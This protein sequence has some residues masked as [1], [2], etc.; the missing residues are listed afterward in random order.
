MKIAIYSISKNEAKHV[1]RFMDSVRDADYV[2]VGDT[3]STDNTCDL[4]VEQGAT[5]L[6]VDVNPWRFDV[7]RNYVLDRLPLDVDVAIALD[8]DEI[9]CFDW[10]NIIEKAWEVNNTT[11]LIYSFVG[12]HRAD[13][14]PDLVFFSKK[15]HSRFGYEWKYPVHETLYPKH[16][17]NEIVVGAPD[18]FIEHFPDHNKPRASYLPLLEL[19][20]KENPDNLQHIMYLAR[21]YFYA[22]RLLEAET[23]FHDFIRREG[24]IVER[25][26]CYRM[27][28]KIAKLKGDM[29][30]HYSM[31]LKACAEKPTER[32]PW[33]DLLE[34]YY[35]KAEWWN[36]IFAAKQGMKIEERPSH[37]LTDSNAWGAPFYDLA[38]LCMWNSELIEFRSDAI[39]TCQRALALC[40]TDPRLQMNYE[41]MNR[42]S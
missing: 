19:S 10:R 35:L 26:F 3:G 15:I 4:L 7:A 30:L 16:A 9:M 18:L 32:E 23:L 29:D 12:S 24:W 31:L 41:M 2:Y 5:L 21:E 22:N 13:G 34:Y 11:R 25:V 27:L 36:G 8:L 1:K 37:Y 33:F 14:T 38:S 39:C 42:I 28:A 40:P 20:V 6:V 17:F